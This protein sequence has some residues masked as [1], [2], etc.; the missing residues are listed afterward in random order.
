MAA[1]TMP[2]AVAQLSAGFSLLVERLRILPI[3]SRGHSREDQPVGNKVRLISDQIQA[4][5]QSLQEDRVRVNV[6]HLV[7]VVRR[8]S[9][10]C[11]L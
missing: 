4:V 5:E 6:S 10:A 11:W 2:D 7:V 9:T 3:L 8:R 1:A